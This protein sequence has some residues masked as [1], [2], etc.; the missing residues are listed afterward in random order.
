M[1]NW[2]SIAYDS[3]DFLVMSDPFQTY[4]EDVEKFLS[5]PRPPGTGMED[6]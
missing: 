6:E 5:K 2:D 4:N 1:I 3:R